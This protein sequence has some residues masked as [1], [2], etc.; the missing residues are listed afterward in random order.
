MIMNPS[1]IQMNDQHD[2]IMREHVYQTVHGLEMRFAIPESVVSLIKSSTTRFEKNRR[3]DPF[4]ADQF[5]AQHGVVDAVDEAG[6]ES[7][8]ASDPPANW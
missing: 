4:S 5:D 7:F 8:P 3:T 1:D 2:A 6:A